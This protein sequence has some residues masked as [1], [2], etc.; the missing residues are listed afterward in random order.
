MKNEKLTNEE[1]TELLNQAGGA[2]F[3]P[4][5]STRVIAKLGRYR[6][7]PVM[8][9]LFRY[10]LLFTRTVYLGAFGLVLLLGFCYLEEGH[11][12]INHLLGLGGFSEED[13]LNFMNPMI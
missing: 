1:M 6:E 4:F 7:S 12:S 9:L 11:L 5:F 3:K 2:A 10:N 13:I 8:G